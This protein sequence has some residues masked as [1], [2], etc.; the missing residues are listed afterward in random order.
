[1][2]DSQQHNTYDIEF[3]GENTLSNSMFYAAL[4]AGAR[5]AAHVGEPEL[6]ERWLSAAELGRG[7]RRRGAVQR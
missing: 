2:L 1:M 6:A 3:Y 4:R 5:I 7:S